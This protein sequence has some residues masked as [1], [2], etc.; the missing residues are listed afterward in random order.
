MSLEITKGPPALDIPAPPVAK[1]KVEALLLSMGSF[2]LTLSLFGL[3][4]LLAAIGTFLPQGQESSRIV[5]LYG[6]RVFDWVDALGFTDI[7]RSAW[8]ILVLALMALNLIM[9]TW[10]RVPHVWRIS[11][12][13]DSVSLKDPLVPKTAFT[14]TW[15]SD[16]EPGEALDRVRTVLQ[17]EFPKLAHK[18]GPRRRVVVGERNF[19][20]LWSAHIVHLG[21]LLLLTAGV[22]KVMFG[23]NRQVVIKEGETASVPV[24]GLKWGL[25]L[26]HVKAGPLDIPLPRFYQHVEGVAPFQLGLEHFE[27][28]YYPGTGAPSLFR[29]DLRV[30]K[31]SQVEKVASVKVNDPLEQD[32][33]MLYQA[34][35]GYEGL[36]SANFT[37]ELPGYKDALDIHAPYQKRIKL[38]D[39]GWELEVT[40][41]YPTAAMAGPGKLVNDGDQLGNP[42]IRVRFWQRGVERAHT[43]FVFSM[44]D[45]QMSKV[46]G[47]TLKGK[48]VDPIAFTVLE[49]N[50]D[51]GLWFAIFGSF[52]VV[53]GVFSAFYLFHRK[54]WVAVEPSLIPGGGCRVTLAGF[55]RRNKVA[56]KRVFDRLSEG[57]DK[58]LADRQGD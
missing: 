19:V 29:S 10:V 41:F 44:P 1:G 46:P 4:G 51:P 42:A 35:W 48:T 21:L 23:S 3:L 25:W 37:V 14:R 16:L 54:A 28:R 20:S 32:G 13:A 15:E 36:Y 8:F 26:D 53:L 52:F 5:D 47:L 12:E 34:S 56:F 22:V 45:I 55:V 39:T 2:K 33:L 50:Y 58:A 38:L 43:W 57:V 24:D 40:D 27:V 7:Y 18:S 6:Q 11:R 49:A 17:T 30:Y 31:D 9:V